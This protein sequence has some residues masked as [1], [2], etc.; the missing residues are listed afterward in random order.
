M[1]VLFKTIY[2][3]TNVKIKKGILA[4]ECVAAF[5]N[6]LETSLNMDYRK[7]Y[8]KLKERLCLF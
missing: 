4:R 5:L 1:P 6:K 8:S 2:I 3:R 7:R